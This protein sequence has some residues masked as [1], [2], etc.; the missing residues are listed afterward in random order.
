MFVYQLICLLEK[1]ILKLLLF[2]TVLR[3]FWTKILSE[4]NCMKCGRFV[5]C[6]DYFD[7]LILG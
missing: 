5:D 2:K 1:G 4:T 7:S 3:L 6:S